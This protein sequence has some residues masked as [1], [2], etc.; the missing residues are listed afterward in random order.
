MAITA[1]LRAQVRIR[2]GFRCEYCQ[3]P[4]TVSRLPL[5]VD[6]IVAL[7]HGGASRLGNLALS[8]PSCN[9]HKGPN[10]SGVDPSSGRIIRLF[11]PRADRCEDHFAWRGVRIVGLTPRGRATINALA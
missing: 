6:H 1:R 8:C 5:V 10:L 2:A 3:L 4:E 9:L 7:Q 11:D